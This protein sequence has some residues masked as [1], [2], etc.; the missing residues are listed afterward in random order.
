MRIGLDVHGVLDHPVHGPIFT[1]FSHD[2]IMAKHEVHIITGKEWEKTVDKLKD[3]GV[4]YTH[5]FSIADYHKEIGTPMTYKDPE[6]P[7]LDSYLW[8]RTKA[9]Y[10]RQM[11]IDIH[12]DDSPVYGQYFKGKT[13]YIKV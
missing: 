2:W 13:V 8:D 12:F 10:C 11:Q 3:I 7:F 9:D 1:I 6:N 4:A 5:H